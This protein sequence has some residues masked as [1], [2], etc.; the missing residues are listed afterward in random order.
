MI[1]DV[2]DLIAKRAA[3][4]PDRVA[5]EEAATGRMLTYAELD[6]RSA[7]AA[8][9]MA[10]AG[11]GAGDRVAILCR[12]RVQFFELLFGCAKIGAILVPLNWRMPPAELGR[13]IEDSEPSLLAFGAED[14]AAAATLL[15]ERIGL[16]EDY[17]TRLQAAPE[18]EFRASWPS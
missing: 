2:P 8:S 13:L 7:R 3:L 12:N 10:E 16:D 17:E 1:G 9:L 18:R 4:A 14:A 5:M 15:P 6:R 11:I